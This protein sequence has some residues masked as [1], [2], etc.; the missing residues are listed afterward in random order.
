MSSAK[1]LTMKHGLSLPQIGSLIVTVIAVASVGAYLL[2]GSYAATPAVAA[3]AETGNVSTPA[4][5]RTDPTASGGA[6]VRFGSGSSTNYDAT[7]MGDHPVAFWAMNS[8]NASETDLTGNG[9]TGNYCSESTYEAG[10]G[11]CSTPFT[12]AL[13]AMPNGES[14]AKF[15]ESACTRTGSSSGTFPCQYMKAS[16]SDAFSIPTTK[17]LTVEAWIKPNVLQHPFSDSTGSYTDWAGK[18]ETYGSPANCEWEGRMYNASTSQY[19]CSRID[20]YVFNSSASLGSAADWQPAGANS[21]QIPADTNYGTANCMQS[22]LAANQWLQVVIEYQTLTTP[23]ACNSSYPGTINIWVNGVEQNFA[24]HQTTGCM[25]QHNIA[26]GNYSSPVDIGTMAHDGFF[27]GAIGKVAI[28]NSV[29]SQTQIN[30]HFTAMTGAAVSGSC[31][32]HGDC[33]IPVPTQ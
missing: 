10:R 16:D 15:N 32:S 21:G 14:A 12:P 20:G 18:C 2:N 11:S 30:N 1:L 29:L 9:H 19:R 31:G 25:S 6:Y 5:V 28:Y 24:Y 7:I 17:Q 26:P 8:T 4:T 22:I 27:D 23:A 13:T 3:E 33:S